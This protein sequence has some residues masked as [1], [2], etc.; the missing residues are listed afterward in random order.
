MSHQATRILAVATLAVAM[1]WSAWAI[2]GATPINQ[3]AANLGGVTS[4]D[5]P[6]FPVSL[7]R[8]GH[9]VLTS[10][11]DVPDA[12]TDGIVFDAPGISL[13]MNGFR[14]TCSACSVAGSG[15]GI[16][17]LSGADD[18]RVYNGTVSQMGS[19]GISL[20]GQRSHVSDVR[21][22]GNRGIGI[23][24]S[25]GGRVTRSIALR[26]GTNGIQAGAYAKV[27]DSIVHANGRHGISGATGGNVV[28][29]VATDNTLNGIQGDY[30]MT[31][32]A[33]VVARNL[34]DGIQGFDSTVSHNNAIQQ[35]TGSGIR[36]EACTVIGNLI[37][38]NGEGLVASGGQ[39][40]YGQ[41]V[42]TANGSGF[43]GP[44]VSGPANE[45]D[46][47]LCSTDT[48]CP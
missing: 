30:G 35:P 39:T 18:A 15:R 47:N 7:S 48:S 5:A 26:N 36:S 21:A 6:G 41:N 31:I 38:D 1:P 46:Q 45:L 27:S 10:N 9:Y 29:S 4:G 17:S 12:N 24:V 20:T 2:D 33:N 37:N 14:L 16:S 8:S 25:L 13:D 3:F 44:Q 34:F 40:G 32:T 42:L 19:D 11:L 23:G 43:Q 28:R 22:I